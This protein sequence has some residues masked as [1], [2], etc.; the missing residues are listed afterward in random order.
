MALNTQNDLFLW[1]VC[2]FVAGAAFLAS[3]TFNVPSGTYV[4]GAVLLGIT[5]FLYCLRFRNRQ[6]PSPR[7]LAVTSNAIL[8]VLTFGVVL[9][10]LGVLTWYE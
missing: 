1:I 9:Y 6:T 4:S 8:V 5:G 3:H 7:L 2:G 10:V